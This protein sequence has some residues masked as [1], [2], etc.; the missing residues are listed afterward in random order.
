MAQFGLPDDSEGDDDDEQQEYVGNAV[1]TSTLGDTAEVC[2]F[3][4]LARDVV[5]LA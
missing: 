4:C 1:K 3:S 5:L 2:Q